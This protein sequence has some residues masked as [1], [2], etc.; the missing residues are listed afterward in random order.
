MPTEPIVRITRGGYTESLHRGAAA[1]VNP[2]GTVLHQ[3]GDPSHFTF[4]RSSAKPLQA[5]P[6][7]EKAVAEGT[8]FSP[9]EIT[10]LC[11]SHNGEPAHVRIVENLLQKMGM[12]RDLLQCGAHEPFYKQAADALREE[13]KA[14]TALHNNCSGKHTG[15]LALSQ[16]LDVSSGH[17]MDPQHPVQQLM[18]KAVSVMAGL[19]ESDIRLGTDGCGVPVFGMPLSNLA[20][21]Y[22]RLGRP[23]SLGAARA[24]ACRQ[25]VG[26]IRAF[27][28]GIAGTGRFDTRLA[29]VTGGR[30]I[31]KMGAE[32]VFSL[33]VPAEGLGIAVKVEDGNLRALYPAVM[34]VLLQLGLL[35]GEESKELRSF[36]RPI[37]HNWSGTKV[38]E[39]IPDFRLSSPPP[40]T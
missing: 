36:H 25:I 17:Y 19:P 24:E 31:G 1:V 28:F 33:T 39:I 4:A 13:G 14:P 34:E 30:I 20:A 10:L 5:I 11:A 35:D 26:A 21:A 16:L 2:E 40:V 7:L 18:L 15:M 9:E 3:V 23:D 6:V 38:G 37:L 32:A 29:E 27:P 22:A 12:S 8:A